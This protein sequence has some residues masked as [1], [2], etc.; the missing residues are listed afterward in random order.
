MSKAGFKA[1]KMKIGLG[2]IKRD[3]ERVRGG[4]RGDRRRHQADGRRQSL[5]YGAGRDPAWAAAGRARHRM[6]R[7]ADLA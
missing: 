3:Y 1:I 6:V 7:G 5:L 2:S 4:A